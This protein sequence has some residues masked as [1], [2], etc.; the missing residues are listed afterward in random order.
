VD[1]SARS[2]ADRVNDTIADRPSWAI[3]VEGLSN[4]HCDGSGNEERA[5]DVRYAWSP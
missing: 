4:N 2:G 1:L 3:V 5:P